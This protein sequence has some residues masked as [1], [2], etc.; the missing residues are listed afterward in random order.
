MVGDEGDEITFVALIDKSGRVQIPA[1]VRRLVGIDG[2]LA[3][4]Q[5][6]MKVLRVAAEAAL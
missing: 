3:T 5:L 2:R 4:V 6:R 1:V